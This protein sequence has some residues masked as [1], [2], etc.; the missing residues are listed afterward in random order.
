MKLTDAICPCGRKF[1][2]FVNLAVPSVAE[3]EYFNVFCA[4]S[5]IICIFLLHSYVSIK[6]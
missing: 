6:I 3:Y 1:S 2:V 5:F 4:K